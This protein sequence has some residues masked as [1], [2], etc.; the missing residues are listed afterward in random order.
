MN[1]TNEGPRVETP[2]SGAVDPEQ[3]YSGHSET[4]GRGRVTSRRHIRR[5]E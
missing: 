4:A 3:T 2:E 1:R 5:S